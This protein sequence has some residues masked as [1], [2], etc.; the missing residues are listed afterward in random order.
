MS[1]QEHSSS[2]VVSSGKEGGKEEGAIE[3]KGKEGAQGAGAAVE[4]T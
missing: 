4:D 1:H 3:V 2:I